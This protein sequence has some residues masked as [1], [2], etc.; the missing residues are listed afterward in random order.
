[1]RQTRKRSGY[2]QKNKS[3]ILDIC[4]SGYPLTV[5]CMKTRS[6]IVKEHDPQGANGANAMMPIIHTLSLCVIGVI[7]LWITLLEF[8]E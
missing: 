6:L 5:D 7:L 4:I 2:A 8:K 1:V 3:S